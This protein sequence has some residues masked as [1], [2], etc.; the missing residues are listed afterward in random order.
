MMKKATVLIFSI[1]F[2]FFIFSCNK[3]KNTIYFDNIFPEEKELTGIEIKEVNLLGPNTICVFDSVL[4]VSDAYKSPRFHFYNKNSLKK[5]TE[6]GV[7]GKGP[8]EFSNPNCINCQSFSLLKN[9]SDRNIML[10]EFSEGLIYKVNLDSI[11]NN[12]SSSIV[13]KR[14]I[15]PE[16]VGADN[17]IKIED[18]IVGEAL[19][20]KKIKYFSMNFKD[21]KNIKKIESKSNI[22]FLEKNNVDDR[23]N[24]ERSFLSYNKTAN[25]FVKAYL[26]FNRVEILDANLEPK[27]TILYGN[28]LNTPNSKRVFS[29]NNVKYFLTPFAGKKSFYLIYIGSNNLN[30]NNNYQLHE[31]DYKGIPLQKI[32]LGVPVLSYTIDEDKNVLYVVTGLENRPIVKFK[33]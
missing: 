32:K 11:L 15:N 1:S 31:F 29:P 6:F 17:L 12:A 2:L 7:I 30:N 5:I 9:N 22:D 21:F 25:K 20:N 16:L 23:V 28:K 33:L 13:E 19:F 27:K 26:R 24:F 3:N 8:N 4:M 14:F 10:Y 18:R